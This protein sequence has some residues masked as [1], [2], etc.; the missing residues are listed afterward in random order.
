MGSV[1]SSKGCWAAQG[2]G[3][4]TDDAA[5]QLNEEEQLLV[6]GRLHQARLCAHPATPAAMHAGCPHGAS[7]SCGAKSQCQC[8]ARAWPPLP[9]DVQVSPPC[10]FL[11]RLPCDTKCSGLRTWVWVKCTWRGAQVLR[12]FM[13]RRTKA[14]VETELPGKAEHIVRCGLSAWQ[15]LWYRQITEEVRCTAAPHAADCSS[16][17]SRFRVSACTGQLFLSHVLLDSRL[18]F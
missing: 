6:I 13:L 5:A 14:E 12:P 15:R 3:T 11:V 18:R 8:R 4:D 9:A 10:A 16:L 2:Q 1:L 17:R 7:P